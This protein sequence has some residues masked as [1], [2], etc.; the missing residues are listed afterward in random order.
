M[1]LQPNTHLAEG[2]QSLS[3]FLTN[4]GSNALS[5]VTIHWKMNDVSQSPI[6]WAGNLPPNDSVQVILGSFSFLAGTIYQ[7]QCYSSTPNSNSDSN[8]SN[9]TLHISPIFINPNSSHSAVYFPGDSGYLSLGTGAAFAFDTAFTFEAWV[10]PEPSNVTGILCSREGEFVLAREADTIV[11]ALNIPALNNWTNIRTNVLVPENQWTHVAFT[12]GSSGFRIYKNG[13]LEYSNPGTGTFGDNFPCQNDL[14]IG[15]RELL[16][17]PFKGLMDEIR[18]WDHAIPASQVQQYWVNSLGIETEPGLVAWIPGGESEGTVVYNYG[19]G[20]HG[21]LEKGASRAISSAPI[22]DHSFPLGFMKSDEFVGAFLDSFWIVLDPNPFSSVTLDGSGNLLISAAPV[23]GGS[24]LSSGTN[25]GAPRILQRVQGNWEIETKMQFAPSNHFQDAGIILVRDSIPNSTIEQRII[26]RRKL[27]TDQ[28]IS[29]NGSPIPFTG[30][31]MFFRVRKTGDQVQAW[32]SIDSLT[33]IAG[34]PSISSANTLIEYVGL[35]AVRYAWDG[36]FN[37]YSNATFEYFHFNNISSYD[38]AVESI[39]SLQDFEILSEG[40]H[41]ILAN[42][43]NDGSDT[44][45]SVDLFWEVNEISQTPMNWTGTLPPGDITSI[46]LG[47][48]NFLPEELY[49]V[50]IWSSQPN[51]MPDQENSNDTLLIREIQVVPNDPHYSVRLNGVDQYLNLTQ[52]GAAMA[53]KTQFTLEFWMKGNATQPDPG[54]VALLGINVNSDGNRLVL[55]MGNGGNQNGK[56]SIV[57]PSGANSLGNKFIGDNQ[58]HH[59]AYVRDGSIAYVYVDGELDFQHIPTFN[60]TASD[61]WSIGQEYDGGNTS[62]FFQGE[63]DGIRIWDVARTP[64]EIRGWR[65]R[66]NNLHNEP[67]LVS[68]WNLWESSKGIAYDMKGGYHAAFMNGYTWQLSSSPLKDSVYSLPSMFSDDFPGGFLNLGWIPISKNQ[69]SYWGLNGMGQ[70]NIFAAANGGSDLYHGTNYNAPRLVQPVGGIANWEIETKLNFDP[71]NLYQSA[72]ILILRDTFLYSEQTNRIF[73]LA[74]NTGGKFLNTFQSQISPFPHSEVYLRIKKTGNTLEKW[75]SLDSVSWVY[76]GQHSSPI[77]DEIEYIGL[78]SIREAHDNDFTVHSS[79]FFDYFHFNPLP[80]YDIALVEFDS[81]ESFQII[82]EA[83]HLIRAK[84]KNVGSHPLSF[85]EIAWEINGSSQS[86]VSWNGNLNP[87]EEEWVSLAQVPFSPGITYD[88][89]A[90]TNLQTGQSDPNSQNDTISVNTVFVNPQVPHYAVSVLGNSGWIEIP[91]HPSLDITGSQITIEGWV[92]YQ[93]GNDWARIFAKHVD[94]NDHPRFMYGLHKDGDSDRLV[95]AVADSVV[96]VNERLVEVITQTSLPLNKWTHISAVYNGSIPE[97]HVYINGV[98]QALQTNILSSGTIRTNDNPIA[99]G[100]NPEISGGSEYFDGAFDEFRLWDTARS[101]AQIKEWMV[102]TNGLENEAGLVSVWHF[103]ENNGVFANDAQGGNTGILQDNPTWILSGAPIGDAAA[104]HDVAVTALQSPSSGCELSSNESVSI[105][106]TNFGSNIE[107]G[108]NVSFLLNDSILVTENIDTLQI[109]PG[110]SKTFVFNSGA[111]LTTSNVNGFRFYSSLSTD[112]YVG[113]DTLLAVVNSYPALVTSITEDTTICEGNTITLTA[114]G[115]DNYLWNIGSVSSNV[116]VSPSDTTLYSVLISDDL[117]CTKEDS[118]QVAIKFLPPTPLVTVSATEICPGD[119]AQLVSNIQT[120]LLWSTGETVD[121]IYVTTAGTYD[122]THTAS[123]GCSTIS[124]PISITQSSIPFISSSGPTSICLGDSISLTVQ[125]GTNYHWSTGAS[126][127]SIKVS[128]TDTSLYSVIIGNSLGCTFFDSIQVNILPAVA[129]APVSNMLPV[130]STDGVSIPILLSWPPAYNASTYDIYIWESG[131]AKPA[132][133]SVSNISQI[134]HNFNGSL[135]YGS[136]YNWQVVAKNSCFSTQ[137][138]TQTFVLRSLP[139][140]IVNDVQIP[141]TANSGQA[142]TITWT[143]KNIGKGGTLSQTWISA[144]FLSSDNVLNL[145]GQSGDTYLG[146]VSNFAALD[147]GESYTQMATYPLPQGIAG[148][149]FIFVWI[150]R[151]NALAEVSDGNNQTRS[152][153][154]VQISLT[155][156]PDLQVTN[157][158]APANAF[159]GNSISI[160]RTV[161]NEGNGPTIASSWNDGIYLSTS[162]VFNQATAIFLKTSQ[163]IGLLEADSS[164]TQ[165]TSVTL[166][167]GIFGTYY[168]H[169]LA[170]YYDDVFEPALNGNNTG[171]SDSI[172]IILTPP[173]DLAPISITVPDTASNR[174]FVIISYQVQNQGAGSIPSNKQWYENILISQYNNGSNFS[175]LRSISNFGPLPAGGIYTQQISVQIPPNFSGPYYI[176]VDIDATNQVYEYNFESNNQLGANIPIEI[177]TPDLTI[178][179]VIVPDTVHTGEQIHIQ[180]WLKNEGLGRLINRVFWDRY[181]ISELPVFDV[182]NSIFV[183]GHYYGASLFQGDSLFR[184]RTILISNGISGPFYVHI[185]TDT[186][187]HVLE[188]P[189]ELNNIGSST[190]ME[191]LLSPWVDLVPFG[192]PVPDTLIA[193]DS[194][195]VSFIVENMGNTDAQGSIWQDELVLSSSASWNPMDTLQLDRF[196]LS[197]Y[198]QVDSSYMMQAVYPTSPYL[199]EGIYYLQVYTDITNQIYEHQSEADNFLSSSPV[200][201]KAY[202]PSDLVVTSFSAS[203]S[204]WSGQSTTV[205]G[206]VTNQGDTEILTSLWKDGVFLSADSIWDV[207]EDLLLTT[208]NVNGPLDSGSSYA[209]A[210]SITIPNGYSGEYYLIF[211]SDYTLAVAD[212][213]TLNNRKVYPIHIQLTPASDLIPT[214]FSAPTT[215]IA[216][217]PISIPIVVNNQGLGTAVA[218]QMVDRLYLSSDQIIDNDDLLIEEFSRNIN[219]VTGQSYSD[220]LEVFLPLIGASGN[221]FLL[222]ASDYNN[223]VYE[224]SNEANNVASSLIQISLPPPADLFPNTI[225]FA[226]TFLVGT[227]VQVNWQLDNI[228]S[229]PAT[230]FTREAVYLSSDTIWDIDDHLLGIKNGN[231]NIAPLSSEPRSID[232]LL[233]GLSV[234]SYY[235]I[236]RSDILNNI[237]EGDES[238]NTRISSNQVYVTVPQLPFFVLTPDILANKAE[239]YYRIEVP[240]SLVGESM[241]LRLTGDSINSFNELYLSH[242]EIPSRVE[243]DEKSIQPFTPNQDIIVPELDSGTYYVMAY[244]SNTSGGIQNVSL[245]ADILTFEIVS[246]DDDKGGNTGSVTVKIK[247]SKFEPNMIVRLEEPSF[248]SITAYNVYYVDPTLV[249]ASFDLYGASI[250]FYDVVL[251]LPDSSIASLVDGFEIENGPLGGGGGGGSGSGSGN[252]NYTCYAPIHLT[253]DFLEVEY[254]LL[255]EVR[256]NWIVPITIYFTNISNVDIPIPKR[257]IVSL[258]DAPIA[259]SVGDLNESKTELFVELKEIGGPPDVLRPKAGGVIKFYAKAPAPP[260]M[261]F[262]LLE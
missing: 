204:L 215:G 159:S 61:L 256:P 81:L 5:S 194:I 234:G 123:N 201:V 183:G 212:P 160:H 111:N 177:V 24:D 193:G 196:T 4:Y 22:A 92:Y 78:F 14:R 198:L 67:G 95:F 56:L 239:I 110:E 88:V 252:F 97:A 138:D 208:I 55:M 182:N 153:D 224:G 37:A 241:L 49:Q 203:D 118:V 199:S 217:Q 178:G 134:N 169:V 210:P 74:S 170:D 26:S 16:P 117:G 112:Q 25:H 50:N 28:Q 202:P 54:Q 151:F 147:S 258:D 179:Q 70:L 253:D 31:D 10:Y 137:G 236:I 3:V 72:G 20:N 75:H 173:P 66:L 73:E 21:L 164:Y 36:D 191:V 235:L 114:S 105:T 206:M 229:N 247:G 79:A 223:Q 261:G 8:L 228:A 113:N 119:S 122:V 184:Q 125:N 108:F 59:I 99:M 69:A 6:I 155:P 90:W 34:P 126:T 106:L 102:K 181:Y 101:Q 47:N 103:G 46:H 250:G 209:I 195:F 131:T 107:S 130:D 65:V 237:P 197:Q 172:N 45:T 136:I 120:D 205:Q 190:S 60:L 262:I 226:D 13:V 200:Y 41:P 132:S 42:I 83:T 167:Q 220:T 260:Y 23:C 43:R 163:H 32:Y 87:G 76:H 251:E 57:N 259:F 82:P 185:I 243:S 214:N 91:D 85:L 140:L 48:V 189:S 157:V 124:L 152:L 104:D 93:G 161:K 244:A 9:D 12:L 109:A 216:G 148:D 187:S 248:G 230:G 188:D 38:V 84:V 246:V 27:D 19:Y 7:L 222:F 62:D 176:Y 53:G 80:A 64:E 94:N 211:V 71:T 98:K 145:G 2:N 154:S 68:E 128:P 139:D 207:N 221:Y 121:T 15:G 218:N 40:S 232:R 17:R 158:A 233:S 257:F 255:P 35:F 58:Y 100:K 143:E 149:Y 63:I 1:N 150:D 18:L 77:Y 142:I 166:P 175:V 96:T 115:G 227:T 242:E 156:P 86:P 213:D 127:Q 51:G 39:D 219:L 180:Y 238:N 133:P 231:I 89:K 116:I 245:L 135:S 174:E 165:S 186:D 240:D 141:T 192:L 29:F 11:C 162:P 33:W 225:S 168:I 146:G 52:F 44:L 144:I 254:V 129:P 171:S 30:T 249:Y